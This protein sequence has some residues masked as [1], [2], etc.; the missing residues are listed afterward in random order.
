MNNIQ[1]KPKFFTVPKIIALVIVTL[2]IVA[3][4]IGFG[5]LK[6][7]EDYQEKVK[8]TSISGVNIA[9]V[10]NG[11]YY[12]EY[13]VD[14]IYAKVKATVQDGT[15][16]DVELIEH[17]TDRGKSA[18]TIV[19]DMVAQQRVDVDAVSGATNS[20]TVIKKAVQNALS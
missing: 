2:L 7:V 4:F 3:A 5:Y 6:T 15:L 1:R 17:R 9:A 10:P 18:E 14:F 8:T 12:G 11:V 16:T 20:S 19:S 13:D